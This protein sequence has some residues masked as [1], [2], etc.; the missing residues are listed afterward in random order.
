MVGL[1][2]EEEKIAF[3]PGRRHRPA[4]IRDAIVVLEGLPA[5]NVVVE[6]SG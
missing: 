4:L 2:A 6:E 5:R 1:V 3:A